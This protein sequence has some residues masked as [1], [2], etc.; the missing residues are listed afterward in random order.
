MDDDQ[1]NY[2]I[3]LSRSWCQWNY[4]YDVNDCE[5][6]GTGWYH[7]RLLILLPGCRFRFR[8]PD[9]NKKIGSTPVSML[10]RLRKIPFTSFISF[11]IYFFYIVLC[12]YTY[13][14]IYPHIYLHIWPNKSRNENLCH[15]QDLQNDVVNA[16]K[17]HWDLSYHKTSEKNLCH[18][19][20]MVDAGHG[21]DVQDDVGDADEEHG[22]AEED[23][24]GWTVVDPT[25]SRFTFTMIIVN[26]GGWIVW[27]KQ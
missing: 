6:H 13:I 21:Q 5:A 18:R 9:V 12:I 25:Q 24:S 16:D 3:W 20:D 22:G 4:N 14:H 23:Q 11:T 7:F 10:V 19:R 2:E 1:K 26:Q 8:L 27:C 15:G 17:E